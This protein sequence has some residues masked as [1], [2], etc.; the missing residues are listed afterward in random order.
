L[1]LE[2]GILQGGL[3]GHRPF[4]VHGSVRTENVHQYTFIPDPRLTVNT[5]A[6]LFELERQISA[7]DRIRCRVVLKGNA[8]LDEEGRR[9]LDGDVFGQLIQDREDPDTGLPITNLILPSG[10]GNKG[11][12]FESWFYLTLR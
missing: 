11:G 9:P 6:P 10:D 12:D 8:I 5:M 2:Q 3:F 1:P 7:T 4:I